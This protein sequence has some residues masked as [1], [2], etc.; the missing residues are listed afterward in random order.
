MIVIV[1]DNGTFANAV[2]A[3]FDISR[4]KA[5]A[6]QTGVWVPLIV[7][8]PVVVQPDRDV[9][10]MVNIV[11]VFR[12]FGELAGIDVAAAVPRTLTPRRCCPT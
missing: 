7:A 11:D 2:K 4:A 10:H 5:T 12:L 3:P 8:G 9:E 6:Y 1:G